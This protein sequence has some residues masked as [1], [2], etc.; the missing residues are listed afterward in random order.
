GR[1][2][3]G[4]AGNGSKSNAAASGVYI[5]G[6]NNVACQARVVKCYNCQGKGYMARKCTQPKRLRNSTWFKEKLMLVEAQESGQV[7]DEEQL[8][9]LADPGVA[10]GQDS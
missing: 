10:V 3:Q 7:L 6:G 2:N 8:A 1:Q 4:F 9:F 5:I